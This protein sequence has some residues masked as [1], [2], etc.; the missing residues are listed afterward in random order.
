MLTLFECYAPVL[1][2]I[3]TVL[4]QPA[5]PSAETV[6]TEVVSLLEEAKSDARKN[7]FSEN[8]FNEGL[9]PIVAWL[10]ET[11]M[12]AR[13]DGAREW[14]NHLLQRRYFGL[15]NF[16]VEFFRRIHVLESEQ[17]QSTRSVLEIYYYVLQLGFKGQYGFGRQE[18]EIVRIRKNIQSVLDP[19]ATDKERGAL[20]G[21]FA[22]P[23]PTADDPARARKRR[24]L[25]GFAL[26]LVPPLVLLVLYGVFSWMIDQ[27]TDSVL[28][29]LN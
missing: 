21:D 10:D 17:K 1:A 7:G 16:G 18:Q 4:T 14:R 22:S 12:C 19:H 20:P 6:R 9:F 2:Y 15:S 5:P 3:E 29:H 23:A 26:Y 8:L 25:S 28:S 24:I 11:L 27:T 13:W